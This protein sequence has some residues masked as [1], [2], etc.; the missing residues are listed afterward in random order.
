MIHTVHLDD[1]YVNIRS[2]LQVI[3]R[4]EYGVRFEH[5][6]VANKVEQDEYMTGEEFWK[7][8]D[9]RILKICKQYG[10]LS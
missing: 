3:N 5:P 10:V 1:K 8:A 7:E 4:Q 9:S 2:L 6:F